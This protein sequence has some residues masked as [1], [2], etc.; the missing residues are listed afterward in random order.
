MLSGAVARSSRS[1]VSS[2]AASATAAAAAPVAAVGVST[3][4]DGES[5]TPASAAVASDTAAAASAADDDDVDTAA[6]DGPPPPP[7]PPPPPTPGLFSLTS[8]GSRKSGFEPAPMPAPATTEGTPLTTGRPGGSGSF[9]ARKPPRSCV[10]PRRAAL[11]SS[12][13]GGRAVR[14]VCGACSISGSERRSFADGRSAG[15]FWRQRW[16]KRGSSAEKAAGDSSA[17]GGDVG[18]RKMARATDD[19]EWCGGCIS[20]ISIA[21]TP[22]AHTSTLASYEPVEI[23]SGASQSG[24]P[25]NVRMFSPELD[26]SVAT[27]RSPSFGSPSCDSRMFDD[28]T[29]RWIT[30]CSPCR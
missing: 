4:A 10:R 18:M 6:A 15:S 19:S 11:S 9:S 17:G 23:A 25:T 8:G 27:P 13:S 20:A 1:S 24:V 7:P 21:V 30:P 26:E 3:S 5:A 12:T 22:S 2:A 14:A 29:S 28:L 16:T